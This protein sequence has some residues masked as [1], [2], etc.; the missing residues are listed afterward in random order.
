MVRSEALVTVALVLTASSCNR[1]PDEDR[2]KAAAA[3]RSSD[4]QSDES[5]NE[6]MDKAGA[7]RSDAG[8][9]D[10]PRKEGESP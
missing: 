8:A 4:E 1:P 9:R 3:R 6:A 10:R 2:A 7:P 5:H